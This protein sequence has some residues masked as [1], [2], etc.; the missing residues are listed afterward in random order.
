[1]TLDTT[2]FSASLDRRGVTGLYSLSESG[3]ATMG[4]GSTT[5][6]CHCIGTVPLQQRGSG[7]AITW[8]IL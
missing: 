3:L 6:C 2:N 5:A 7:C 1:M 8:A 4:T